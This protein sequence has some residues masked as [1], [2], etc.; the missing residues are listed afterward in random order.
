MVHVYDF[1]TQAV[2]IAAGLPAEGGL[3]SC[4][5]GWD[6]TA[7]VSGGVVRCAGSSSGGRLGVSSGGAPELRSAAPCLPWAASAVSAGFGFT[8]ALRRGG[9]GVCSWGCAD[10]GRLGRGGD[11]AEPVEV[12][13][14]PRRDS[15]TLLSAGDAFVIAVTAAGEA[16]GWGADDCG[17]LGRG[18]CGGWQAEP[19]RL[20]PLCARGIRRLACGAAFA[21]AETHEELLW[22]G[23]RGEEGQAEPAQLSVGAVVFPLRCMAAGVAHAAAVDACGAVWLLPRGELA[24]PVRVALPGEERAVRVAAA[25][26]RFGQSATVILTER[27]TLFACAKPAS[28]RNIS[29]AHPELPLG[30]LPHGGS[31]ARRVLLVP[32][33][34]CGKERLRMLLLAAERRPLL[35]RGEMRRIA[36]VPF[37]VD[38]D[39][40]FE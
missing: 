4:S 5:E 28:C 27:G 32:D 26:S 37:L 10:N 34:S 23:S 8:V 6:H 3:Q 11:G 40:I 21:V 14:L 1:R 38:E 35:P 31:S 2:T 36:L 25:C 33:P 30:L 13:G 7:A 39:Y 9:G 16:Y 29:A 12:C 15:V 20:A 19:V 22:W 17:Q 18:S 24:G